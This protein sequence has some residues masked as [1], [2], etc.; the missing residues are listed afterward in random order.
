MGGNLAFE[1]E[2]KGLVVQGEQTWDDCENK[3]RN[4]VLMNGIDWFSREKKEDA[5]VRT[6]PTFMQAYSFGPS[7][8]EQSS[9]QGKGGAGTA[10]VGYSLITYRPNKYKYVGQVAEV[11][12]ACS[13]PP[14]ANVHCTFS[15][16]S[17]L[18]AQL[19]KVD[20]LRTSRK[21]TCDVYEMTHFICSIAFLFPPQS[22]EK[23]LL[24]YSHNKR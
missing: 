2:R 10:D 3:G 13:W 17:L 23:T 11:C 15:H 14:F 19:D 9:L 5:K 20:T 1:R 12:F 24:S 6:V 7:L 18:M 21:D 22:Q 4:E 8:D 16:L